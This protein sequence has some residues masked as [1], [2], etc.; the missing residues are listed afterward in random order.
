MFTMFY[1]YAGVYLLKCINSFS[2]NYCVRTF[3]LYYG[4][5]GGAVVRRRTCDRKVA[6]STP[7]RALSSKL[8]HLS[9]PSLRGR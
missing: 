8:S 2:A 7:G 6:G 3:T 9:L 4:G 5:L 1:N